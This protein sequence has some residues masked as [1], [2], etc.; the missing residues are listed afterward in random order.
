MGDFSKSKVKINCN[1]S[2]PNEN[3]T[4]KKTV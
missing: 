3:L 1:L 4:S 2:T